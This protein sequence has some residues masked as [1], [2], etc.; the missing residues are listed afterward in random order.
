MAKH[1]NVHLHNCAFREL[2]DV[3]ITIFIQCE[4]AC[5][6]MCV[7]VCVCV[8]ARARAFNKT[9]FLSVS[10]CDVQKTN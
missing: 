2:K 5:A 10:R 3:A 6:R 1:E 8:R 7:C 9:K 4:R